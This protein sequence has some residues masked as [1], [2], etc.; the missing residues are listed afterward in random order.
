MSSQTDLL[1]DKKSFNFIAPRPVYSQ[2][3]W[4]R[5][6]RPD[7]FILRFI[8][9]CLQIAL[10][11]PRLLLWGLAKGLAW[12]GLRILPKILLGITHGLGAA[13]LMA[14]LRDADNSWQTLLL[15]SARFFR[16]SP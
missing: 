5:G 11:V 6:F 12:R 10:F 16:G 8:G 2:Q 4:R 14:Q 15:N 1:Y 9:F 7:K 3:E 13:V